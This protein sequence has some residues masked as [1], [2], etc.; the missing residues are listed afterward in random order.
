MRIH[1]TNCITLINSKHY[2]QNGNFKP[3]GLW[4][5]IDNEW[6]DWCYSEMPHWIKKYLFK[7]DIDTTNILIISNK[8]ELDRFCKVY[9]RIIFDKLVEINWE[10]VRNDYKGIEITNYYNLKWNNNLS[11]QSLTWF[12]SWDVSGGCIWDL[13]ALKSFDK[14]I[15][16]KKWFNGKANRI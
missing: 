4:Y 1:N 12:C 13:R 3:N 16:P 15:T 11:F 14:V 9:E 2:L 10:K 7:L 5:G 6:L 8:D